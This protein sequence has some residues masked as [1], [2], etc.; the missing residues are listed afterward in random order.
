MDNGKVKNVHKKWC[1]F[2]RTDAHT[3]DS[4]CRIG[5]KTAMNIN[6]EKAKKTEH[7]HFKDKPIASSK[8]NHL[9]MKYKPTKS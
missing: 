7:K 2:L 6:T 1:S 8:T 5:S 9:V 4:F 3:Q